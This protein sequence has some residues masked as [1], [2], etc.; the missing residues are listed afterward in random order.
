MSSSHPIY[1]EAA[2]SRIKED[3]PIVSRWV[4]GIGWSIILIGVVTALANINSESPRLIPEWAGWLLLQFGLIAA[5]FHAAVET[6]RLFRNLIGAAGAIGVAGGVLLSSIYY[7]NWG[8]GLLPFVPGLIFV[9]LFI[10]R[11]DEEPLRTLSR[12]GLGAAGALMAVVGLIGICVYSPWVGGLGVVLAVIGL[13]TLA[14]FIGIEGTSSEVARCVAIAMGILGGLV[15]LY[16]LGR[17]TVPTLVHDWREPARA[18]PRYLAI[19]GVLIAALA[20]GVRWGLPN[21]L[22]AAPGSST[23][24]DLRSIGNIGLIVGVILLN[25]GVLRMFADAPIRAAGW[26][27]REPAGYLIPTGAVLMA[28]GFIYGLVSL[29]FWSDN[30][31]VVMTRRE[32]FA[33]F[34][35]P[36]F[37]LVMVAFTLLGL[38]TYFQFLET[39]LEAMLIHHQ[40]LEE[41]IVR[42]F[43]LD[44]LP[45]F[46]IIVA[47]PALT[48]RLVSEEKRSGTLEVLL[49]APL[50]EWY[51]VLSKFFASLAVFVLLW[52]P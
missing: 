2:P 14:I 52:L 8:I 44:V 29:G 16:A 5:F 15:F 9:V 49:T 17:S 46:G 23:N 3:E 4:G 10:R 34:Y 38:W 22:Q 13:A 7:S 18:Y 1:A 30:R 28:G 41:P 31:L 36:I 51:V 12:Y 19:G 27:A 50:S 11:E 39:I 40:P 37:Y 32:L 45:V 47:I 25:V 43:V 6:E 26:G 24:R 20:A 33:Y 21:L 48:M 42:A 35:S